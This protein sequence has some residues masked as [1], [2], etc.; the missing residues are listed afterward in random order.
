MASNIHRAQ[1]DYLS[2][3]HEEGVTE[4]A[5]PY[6]PLQHSDRLP[7]VVR[8]AEP[9]DASFL[10]SSWL[11]SYAGQHRDQPKLTVYKMHRPIVERLLESAVTL[12]AVM[13]N[14]SDQILSW[15][16]AERIP[17]FLVAHYC[18][19]KEAFRRFGL[20]KALLDAFDYRKGE[21]IAVSHK[22]YIIKDLKDRYNFQ[23]IPYLQNEGGL[24]HLREIYKCA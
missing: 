20:V 22:G 3:K 6:N 23:Y 24:D 4:A 1:E 17:K 9:Q 15:M 21:P 5:P 10:Y 2:Y 19:T 16:C 8:P 12:V 14:D 18:Y 7:V 11:E 13:E